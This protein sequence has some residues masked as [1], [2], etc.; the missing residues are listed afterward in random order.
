MNV[1]SLIYTGWS[2]RF[3]GIQKPLAESRNN[4]IVL[5]LLDQLPYYQ[6]VHQS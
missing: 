4:G 6:P 1:G 5:N 3:S 2:T